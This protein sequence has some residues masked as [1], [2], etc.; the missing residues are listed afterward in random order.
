MHFLNQYAFYRRSPF[1]VTLATVF[2]F[3]K[4]E[5]QTGSA[6]RLS[7][8]D[9]YSTHG[10]HFPGVSISYNRFLGSKWELGAGLAYSGT[11]FHDDNG[12]NLYALR[13]APVYLSEYYYI[14]YFNAWAPYIHLQEGISF[15]RYDKEF[16]DHPGTRYPIKE[17]GFYGYGGAGTRY[18]VSRR[19]GFFIEAGMKAFHLSFN[20]LDV[21]PHGFALKLGY[22]YRLK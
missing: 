13:F 10:T 1:F 16:Q 6:L 11:S 14:G 5:A 20:N 7:A 15:A 18:T 2:L 4:T 17:S 12:W 8:E 19:S 3:V 21:N 9:L 22:V